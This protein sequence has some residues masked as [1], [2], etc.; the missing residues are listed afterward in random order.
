MLEEYKLAALSLKEITENDKSF[1]DAIKGVL[2][3]AKA[4]NKL[5]GPV[6][7]ILGCELRHHLLLNYLVKPFELEDDKYLVLIA[8]ANHFFLKKYDDKDVLKLVKEELKDKFTKEL[9]KLMSEEN[10]ALDLVSKDF[11]SDS[12]ELVS[13]RF[14][15]PTYLLKMWFKHFGKS[16]TYKTLKKN[17]R[18]SEIYYALNYEKT[19][20]D[21]FEGN[22]K[23]FEKTEVEGVYRALSKNGV[24]KLPCYIN[25]EIYSIRLALKAILNKIDYSKVEEMALYTGRDDSIV[26]DLF[27]RSERKKGLHVA[28][29]SQ[30]ER[31]EILRLM[32]LEKSKNINYFEITDFTNLPAHISD[33][34]DLVV[35]YPKSS[36]FDKISKYPDYL[37][38]FKQNSLD[39]LIKNQREA[40]RGMA[41]LLSDDGKLLYIVDTLDRKESLSIVNEFLSSHKDF[42]LVE[43][44]QIFPHNSLDGAFYYALIEKKHD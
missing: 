8:L 37:I 6:S 43:Q 42:V 19:T 18:P 33:K 12:L 16:L 15:V 14:N 40:L 21:A 31:A 22:Y 35:V 32:R 11:E 44:N 4:D 36:S 10:N 13:L 41:S 20:K 1:K 30:D 26:R 25:F 3:E 5:S 23:D 7:A 34:Q 2:T 39:E 38:H 24:H 29:P 28:V 17:I 9:E 27:Y